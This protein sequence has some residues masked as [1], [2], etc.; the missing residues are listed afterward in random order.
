[1]PSTEEIKTVA[2]HPK[3][4]TVGGM[5]VTGK[6]TYFSG[7]PGKAE[8]RKISESGDSS[9]TTV[10]KQSFDKSG[11]VIHG[12]EADEKKDYPTAAVKHLQNKPTA[13]IQPKH[14]QKNTQMNRNIHQPR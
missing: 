4:Q 8:G 7:E 6:T 1:M 14:E 10:V 2:G 3:V 9:D 12:G 13:V 5:R 11:M